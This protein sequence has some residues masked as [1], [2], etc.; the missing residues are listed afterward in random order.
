MQCFKFKALS[1]R[2][3]VLKNSFDEEEKMIRDKKHK[4]ST[5]KKFTLIEL[6]VV[7]AIIA[8]LAAILLPALN[9][10]RT[11]AKNISC[12]NNVKQ[13]GKYFMS[14]GDDHDG[15]LPTRASNNSVLPNSLY[16]LT[17]FAEQY[18]G[19]TGLHKKPTRKLTVFICPEDTEW[20][21]SEFG[22]SYGSNQYMLGG[23]SKCTICPSGRPVGK[24]SR[25]KNPSRTF[26]IQSSVVLSN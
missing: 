21:R 25:F 24:L 12:L 2:T 1:Q 17:D 15:Y 14:Y 22:T 19:I 9:R 11:T 18:A 3:E 20:K 7:I 26:M 23:I 4:I 16:F 10:A 8:V 13:L 6:L 5:S